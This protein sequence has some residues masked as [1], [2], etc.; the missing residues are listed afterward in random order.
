[1][2]IIGFGHQKRV[3]KDTATKFAMSFARQYRPD[4]KI[5]VLSF[6][7]MLKEIAYCMYKWGGLEQS[8]YYENHSNEI[9]EVIPAIGKSPRQ[10]WDIVG[11]MGRQISDK[12]WVELALE[13]IG[14][15]LLICK[16]IRSPVEFALIKETGTTIKI[17]RDNAPIGGPV[18][19][20]LKDVPW[21]L[22]VENNGTLRDLNL[23]IKEIIKEKIDLWFPME[24]LNAR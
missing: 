24:N 5:N 8:S 7:D 1:M 15:D 23:R 11:M 12:T 14:S 20:L 2:K 18:D 16:D 17:T 6:G 13:G 10:I 9:E 19:F 21:G 3:G 4:L 22:V